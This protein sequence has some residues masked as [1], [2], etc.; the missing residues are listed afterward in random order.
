VYGELIITAVS[1]LV[2]DSNP[3]MALGSPPVVVPHK[4]G[5]RCIRFKIVAGRLNRT[6]RKDLLL[7]AINIVPG[8]D[9]PLN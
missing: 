5:N 2:R 4:P 7:I 9:N 6:D 1:R 8:F 3:L